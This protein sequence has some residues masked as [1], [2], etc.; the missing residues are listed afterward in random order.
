MSYFFLHWRTEQRGNDLLPV[1]RF[2]FLES[3]WLLKWRQFLKFLHLPHLIEIGLVEG[4]P[5]YDELSCSC[6]QIALYH[7]KRFDAKSGPAGTVLKNERRAVS[8]VR[9]LAAC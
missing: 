8:G 2:G 7:V 6:G 1:W 5:L 3:S 9:S 4:C